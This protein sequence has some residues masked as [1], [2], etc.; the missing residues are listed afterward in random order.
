M[1]FYLAAADKVTCTDRCLFRHLAPEASRSEAGCVQFHHG[2][3]RDVQSRPRL[4]VVES[5]PS[6]SQGRTPPPVEETFWDLFGSRGEITKRNGSS[7][8]RPAHP[9]PQETC[10]GFR[11]RGVAL[12]R[13]SPHQ[14]ETAG[15]SRGGARRGEAHCEMETPT[16]SLP[17]VLR[18]MKTKARL[19]V[20]C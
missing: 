14:R 11:S 5:P 10:C 12:S 7:T 18:F 3:K 9:Q 19:A 1:A 4:A 16:P 13:H 6:T 2:A 15:A 8:P 20:E 17:R